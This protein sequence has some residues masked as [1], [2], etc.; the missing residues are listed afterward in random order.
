MNKIAVVVVTYNAMP[1]I[2]EC[3]NSLLQSTLDLSII[4]VDNCSA[5]D[6]VSYINEHY[7]D[8]V[9]LIEL[10][11]NVGF[12]RGN[13]VGIREALKA[14]SD[15]VFL[16]N[17]DA[18]VEQNTIEVLV[19]LSKKNPEYGILSPIHA[20]GD[21]TALEQSFL[22]YITNGFGS[23][24]ISD[25]VLERL[26]KPIY[27]VPMVNAAAWLIPRSTIEKVG[28]FDPMFFLYGEDDNYCQ[29]VVYHQFKIGIASKAFIRHDSQNN[30]SKA[31]PIGSEKYYTLFLNRIK[32]TYGNVNKEAYKEFGKVKQYF[33]MR[34]LISLIKFDFKGF[35]V[36][37]KKWNLLKQLDIKNSVLTN[38]K[39]GVNYL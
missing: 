39:K 2:Q 38:R 18:F 6:T 33:F 10:K 27:N 32:V 16:L 3:L 31:V 19:E 15:Y 34:S 29:R 14:T 30:N 9:Q 22:Y 13:N 4:V 25:F 17:Q 20:N 12:G 5:D 23:T 7:K 28:G 37:L 26:K 8:K 21:G 11:T 36:N 1:W 35:K 24:F